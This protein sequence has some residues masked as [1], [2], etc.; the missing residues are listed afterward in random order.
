LSREDD[1]QR[2]FQQQYPHIRYEKGRLSGDIL[3]RHEVAKDAAFFLCGPP[4]M[5]EAALKELD[6]LHVD[7]SAVKQENFTWQ[8]SSQKV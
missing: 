8:E 2:H 1:V 7:P 6:N 3:K 5:M 4:P